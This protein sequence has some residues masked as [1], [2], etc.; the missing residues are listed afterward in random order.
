MQFAE[1]EVANVVTIRDLLRLAVNRSGAIEP[2]AT[3]PL[4]PAEENWIA[5]I[6]LILTL[7]G[8]TLYCLNRLLM[9]ALFRVQLEGAS[10]PLLGW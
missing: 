7:V 2:P 10:A 1:A 3:V 5:P 4:A 8:L 9:R 6:G